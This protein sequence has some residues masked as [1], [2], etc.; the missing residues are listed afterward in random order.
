LIQSVFVTRQFIQELGLN[1][2]L[3]FP[4]IYSPNGMGGFSSGGS[5]KFVINKGMI[6]KV[7]F[8]IQDAQN[9][10]IAW[11]GVGTG[12]VPSGIAFDQEKLSIAL[13]E[14]LASID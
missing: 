5:S 7:I 10:E 13:D 8:L 2:S 12:I 14:L 3:P 11:M 6:G 9:Y 1:S 4:F